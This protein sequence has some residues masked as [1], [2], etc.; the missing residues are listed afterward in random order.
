MFVQVGDRVEEG[1]K[2]VEL[3]MPDAIAAAAVLSGANA[4][5]SAHETRRD[6]LE[7]LKSQ[8]L[9]GASDVFDVESGIGKLSADRRLALATLMAAGIDSASGRRELLAHGTVILTAP[10]AGVVA[11]LDAT[12]GDVVDP[13]EN[14]AKILG[15]GTARIEVAFTGAVPADVTLEFVGTDGSRFALA[16]TPVSTAIEPG[17]RANPRV[18]RDRGRGRARPR[19]SRPRHP[20]RRLG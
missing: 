7:Q 19:G 20:P 3:R 15:Q 11:K 2:L 4:Q 18:V 17:P 8:G 10:V 1:A 13:G 5:L 14:L 16:S 12:P 6:R 9:V